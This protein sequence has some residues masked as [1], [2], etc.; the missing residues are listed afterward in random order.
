MAS[1]FAAIEL[2]RRYPTGAEKTNIP[3]VRGK[4]VKKYRFKIFYRVIDTE[5]IVEIV[6]I[7]RLWQGE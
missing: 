7:R 2:T 4:I 5:D 1:I 6:H 3:G